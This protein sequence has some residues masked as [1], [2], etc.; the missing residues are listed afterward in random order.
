MLSSQWRS[1]VSE[2]NLLDEGK[3]T[4]HQCA[5]GDHVGTVEMAMNWAVSCKTRVWKEGGSVPMNTLDSF[6]LQD[7]DLIKI[8]A[9]G[10]EFNIVKGGAETIQRCRPVMIVEQKGHGAT[11]YGLRKEEAVEQL[12]RLGM[13]RALEIYGDWIMVWP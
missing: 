13:R 12:E 5:L 7:V 10:Y 3:V 2:M 9:E 8:D 1:I 4:L 6:A 11:Y